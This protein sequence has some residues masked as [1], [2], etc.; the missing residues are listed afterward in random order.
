MRRWRGTAARFRTGGRPVEVVDASEPPHLDLEIVVPLEDMTQQLDMELRRDL[1]MQTLTEAMHFSVAEIRE[2]ISHILRQPEMPKDELTER[3][4]VID[5][6]SLAIEDQLEQVQSEW[7]GDELGDQAEE[8][9]ASPTD[10][11]KA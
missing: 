6:A 8:V 1:T 10:K 11:K 2:S 5:R 3:R 4:T 7:G 9:E